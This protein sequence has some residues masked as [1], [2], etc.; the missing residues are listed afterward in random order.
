M[1]QP[2][3]R[4]PSTTTPEPAIA[5]A[6]V[7]RRGCFGMR[8]R[9]RAAG[10]RSAAESK[11]P[12]QVSGVAVRVSLLTGRA[13][14]AVAHRHSACWAQCGCCS[15]CGLRRSD[16]FPAEER[17]AARQASSEARSSRAATAGAA[18]AAT[19]RHRREQQQSNRHRQWSSDQLQRRQWKAAAEGEHRA[20]SNE[21][22]SMRPRSL[23]AAVAR[24]SA[25]RCALCF[26]LAL[27]MLC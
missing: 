11:L 3:K 9:L 8:I 7:T 27:T 16:R 10:L 17:E 26:V 2:S 6:D 23:A 12:R 19:S 5:C 14:R 18:G 24:C 1:Q 4:H 13:S 22:I 20:E 21:P 25:A 15:S